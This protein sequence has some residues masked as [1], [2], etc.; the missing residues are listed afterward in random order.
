MFSAKT[1]MVPGKLGQDGHPEKP[2]FQP[3]TS[4]SPVPCSG[5]T[6]LCTFQD[7][8]WLGTLTTEANSAYQLS[9]NPSL[10]QRV[11]TWALSCPCQYTG[12]QGSAK[13]MENTGRLL[14][15]V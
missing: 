9:V 5:P 8:L 7:G 6:T 3:F 10:I 2:T 4:P 1:G 12:S 11:F 15:V 14:K 13:D